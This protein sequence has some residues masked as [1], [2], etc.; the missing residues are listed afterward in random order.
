[1][2]SAT[3]IQCAAPSR[4]ARQVA[5]KKRSEVKSATVIQCALRNRKARQVVYVK[6]LF[7][8]E[9]RRREA[10]E[11]SS[12]LRIQSIVRGNGG[13]QETRD[14]RLQ[15]LAVRKQHDLENRA[16]LRIQ[17]R[18]RG[19][20]GRLEYRERLEE[21]HRR[22]REKGS[23]ATCIQRWHRSVQAR[24]IL[25]VLIA[26]KRLK[27]LEELSAVRI[28]SGYRCSVA[29]RSV[30]DAREIRQQ[31]EVTSAARC[32]AATRIQ[33]AVRCFFVIRLLQRA[34]VA[35]VCIQS[36]YRGTC[37]RQSARGLRTE[38]MVASLCRQLML[39]PGAPSESRRPS[40][41]SAM[42]SEVTSEC[43]VIPLAVLLELPSVVGSRSPS[44]ESGM[45]SE[46]L[47]MCPSAYEVVNNLAVLAPHWQEDSSLCDGSI[48][49]FPSVGEALP[50]DELVVHIAPP[51][52]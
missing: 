21:H 7:L 6:R 17:S 9:R 13:R 19:C 24:R 8:E 43:E 29:R 44:K 42:M 33:S 4:Q 10:L 18:Y 23:S 45:P 14:R 49:S 25:S 51:G 48:E 46:V 34:A 27:S 52:S 32:A 41:E 1:V 28:Q 22:D 5:A 2:P 31:A 35:A 47:S 15:Q 12:A 50:I 36:A 39:T 30:C 26:A 16:A 20:S 38:H 37:G 40:K 11:C 3:R